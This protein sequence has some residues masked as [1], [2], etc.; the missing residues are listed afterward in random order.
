MPKK[1]HHHN[2]TLN[3]S[4]SRHE[5]TQWIEEIISKDYLVAY[6]TDF[7][8]EMGKKQLNRNIQSSSV[9]D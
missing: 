4:T 5:S 1:R 3:A 9:V 2:G 8:I 6:Y 7:I